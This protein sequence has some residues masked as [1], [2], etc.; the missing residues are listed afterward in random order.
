MPL[1]GINILSQ[2]V[3]H[4]LVI[5]AML[6]NPVT[7]TCSQCNYTPYVTDSALTD[8]QTVENGQFYRGFDPH[9]VGD[10]FTLYISVLF[11]NGTQFYTEV[12]GRPPAITLRWREPTRVQ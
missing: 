11:S 5:N 12:G 4:G 8:K 2:N 6:M 10:Q 3:D 7:A 9:I 1:G